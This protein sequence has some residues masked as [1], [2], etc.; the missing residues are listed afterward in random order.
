MK[1]LFILLLLCFFVMPFC[2][3]ADEDEDE[4]GDSADKTK[5][6]YED[7]FKDAPKK[8]AVIQNRAF[9]IGMNLDFSFS[10]NL[11]SVPSVFK[12][13]IVVNMDDL[14][15]G[16]KLDFGVNIRPFY[17]MIDS[18]KGWGFG[19]STDIESFGIVDLNQV[20]LSFAQGKDEE[21]AASAAVFVSAGIDT[22][23]QV[24]KFKV[25]L[26]PAIFYSAAYAKADASY[27]FI[28]SSAGTEMVVDYD[29][30]IYTAFPMEDDIQ[31]N[32]LTGTPGFDVSFGL[33]YPLSKEFGISKTVFDF[34]VGMDF[35]NVPVLSSKLKN[36]KRFQGALGGGDPINVLD[37]NGMKTLIDSMTAGGYTETD[38]IDEQ[39]IERPFK[40]LLHAKWRPTGKQS[41]TIIPMFGFAINQLYL[42]PF[43]VEAGINMRLSLANIFVLLF[44]VNYIDRA[45]NNSFDFAV[46]FKTFEINI[47]AKMRSHDFIKSWTGYGVGANIGIKL[48][49]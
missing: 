41:L 26:R 21:S 30:R 22:F 47:G 12:E 11:F 27:S 38:G 48:G 7:P 24:Q 2:L 16:L 8:E 34:D 49:L 23:F 35:V 29:V 40:L 25:K 45:W 43:G 14:T 6:K 42:D 44:G 33:E 20:M 32:S 4:A 10:N 31:P 18:K 28:N 5:E 39:S 37:D 13:T 36:Y 46:N 9:E 3:F 19:L 17:F 1:K 15:K